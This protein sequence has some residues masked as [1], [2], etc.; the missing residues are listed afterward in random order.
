MSKPV[1]TK[2]VTRGKAE[3]C[4]VYL[5]K[6]VEFHLNKSACQGACGPHVTEGSHRPQSGNDSLS[7]HGP[8]FPL[9]LSLSTLDPV[10]APSLIQTQLLTESRHG[11]TVLGAEQQ[12]GKRQSHGP[13]SPSERGLQ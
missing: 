4:S 11:A 6:I 13:R 8:L 2:T 5:I 10:L 9:Y 12:L 1:F 7:L 3:A